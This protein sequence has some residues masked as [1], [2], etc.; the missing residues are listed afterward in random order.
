MTESVVLFLLSLTVL[1]VNAYLGRN[2]LTPL[3]VYACA[4]FLTLGIAYLKMHTAM[5]D[6]KPL[7][8]VVVVGSLAAFA[9]GTFCARLAQHG[10][11]PLRR[12][13]GHQL[14]SPSS[15][16]ITP[17]NWKR[18]TWITLFFFTLL[19]V[20]IFAEI[21]AIG[22][23]ILLSDRPAYYIGEGYPVHGLLA[24][25]LGSSPMVVILF[26]FGSFRSL[27]PHSRLRTFFRLMALIT[28]ALAILSMPTRSYA[29]I[30]I[31]F[32]CFVYNI[33]SKRL[34]FAHLSI[35]IVLVLAI[36]LYI[37]EKKQQLEIDRSGQNTASTMFTLPYLYLANNWWNLDYALNPEPTIERH[38]TTYGLDLLGGFFRPLPIL[39]R[40][41]QNP[42]WDNLLN[43][44]I[45][46]V[47][48][49]NTVGYQWNLYKDFGILGPML[50]PFIFGFITNW[51]YTQ[52]RFRN[53]TAL[54]GTNALFCY[55]LVFLSLGAIWPNPNAIFWGSG[56][57]FVF[58]AS[59][60]KDDPINAS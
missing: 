44:R 15:S 18:Y 31:L 28:Y 12:G 20:G 13:P 3:T 16:V 53:S 42:Y 32:G 27:N 24:Y 2:L 4:Q 22:T 5:T 40:I 30:P 35:G 8:W 39:G 59:S 11:L 43:P 49:L 58:Y 10:V 41:Y 19:L 37:A 47:K 57:L 36:F 52:M 23:F 38:P 29:I 26:L 6:F 45:I 1:G 51:V 25:M 56:L 9:I 34:R 60:F 21:R 14:P 33:A 55:W 17:F 7:T 46:K 54:L 48:G 50:I